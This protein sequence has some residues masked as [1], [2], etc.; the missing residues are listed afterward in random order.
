MALDMGAAATYEDLCRV[1]LDTLL[2]A[3]PAEVAGLLDLLLA[4]VPAGVATKLTVGLPALETLTVQCTAT[5]SAPHGGLWLDVRLPDGSGFDVC[6]RLR[7][8]G[9]RLPILML[10]V[11]G[12]ETDKVL[13]LEMGADDYVTKPIDRHTLLELLARHAVRLPGPAEATA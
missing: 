1:V 7:D 10:T 9:L 12:D 11:Q 8:A 4:S 5:H 6:R 13:G 3:T 2:E